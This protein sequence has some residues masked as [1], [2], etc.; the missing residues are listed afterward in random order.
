MKSKLPL[1]ETLSP[2]LD[3]VKDDDSKNRVRFLLLWSTKSL[4]QKP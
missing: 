2:S 3:F 1:E 4:E